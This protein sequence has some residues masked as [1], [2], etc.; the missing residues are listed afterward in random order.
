MYQ[1]LVPGH[2]RPRALSQYP[3]ILPFDSAENNIVSD[4]CFF[5]RLSHNHP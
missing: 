2:K 4:I 3:R 5:C 1:D